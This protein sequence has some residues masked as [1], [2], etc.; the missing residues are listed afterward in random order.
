[1]MLHRVRQWWI[2][3]QAEAWDEASGRDDMLCAMDAVTGAAWI[4]PMN[5]RA[6]MGTVGIIAM[7]VDGG[8]VEV[9]GTA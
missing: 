9:G 5:A 2:S 6:R 1:M 3:L 7:E 8:E 4:C